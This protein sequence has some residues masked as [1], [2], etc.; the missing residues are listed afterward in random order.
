[1]Q[2]GAL[3]L[4]EDKFSWFW[5]FFRQLECKWALKKSISRKCNASHFFLT[6]TQRGIDAN[7]VSYPL[8]A[9]GE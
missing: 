9:F 1:M 8:L 6:D 5:F 7:I 4:Q 3:L 2:L